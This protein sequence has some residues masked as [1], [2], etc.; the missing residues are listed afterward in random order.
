[1][2]IDRCVYL[3]LFLI[4]QLASSDSG[5]SKNGDDYESHEKVMYMGCFASIL[6]TKAGH[7]MSIDDCAHFCSAE[8]ATVYL[9]AFVNGI[10]CFCLETAEYRMASS[11]CDVTC[12]EDDVIAWDGRYDDDD[13]CGVG[14]FVPVFK[15]RELKDFRHSQLS[16]ISEAS[17]G[18]KQ[19]H[20]EDASAQMLPQI[21]N[22]IIHHCLDGERPQALCSN[23]CKPGW[24]GK[25]CNTRDCT[26]FNGDC[27]STRICQTTI[28]IGGKY[29]ECV[30][31]NPQHYQDKYGNCFPYKNRKNAAF[32]KS[33]LTSSSSFSSSSSS[34]SSSFSSSS[35]PFP[36]HVIDG[37]K[38]GT[39]IFPLLLGE[40]VAVDLLQVSRVHSVALHLQDDCDDQTPP[41]S[42]LIG[43]RASMQNFRG[44]NFKLCGRIKPTDFFMESQQDTPSN[45]K[46]S[47]MESQAE[48]GNGQL[49]VCTGRPSDARFVIVQISDEDD[50]DDGGGNSNGDDGDSGSG[51]DK[52]DGGGGGGKSGGGEGGEV[53]KKFLPNSSNQVLKISEIDV[54]EEDEQVE[55]LQYVGCFGKVS[56]A[57]NTTTDVVSLDNCFRFCFALHSPHLYVAISQQQLQKPQI[58][59]TNTS[60]C[61]CNPRLDLWLNSENCTFRCNPEQLSC[62]GPNVFSVYSVVPSSSAYRICLEHCRVQHSEYFAIKNMEDCFC[63]FSTDQLN[64]Q[65]HIHACNLICYDAN[66]KR[67][68]SRQH[69]SVYKIFSRYNFLEP[70]Q[71]FHFCMNE[72]E[73]VVHSCEPGMCLPG[74]T[75][76]MCDVRNCLEN[77]GSCPHSSFGC[78]TNMVN[79]KPFD[80]CLYHK[81][82]LKPKISCLHGSIT[83]PKTFG[84]DHCANILGA[85]DPGESELCESS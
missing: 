36:G 18:A 28:I 11:L 45:D 1:M 76:E 7:T 58:S 20:S 77:K 39:D 69:F 80:E 84:S 38:A 46:K 27:G 73:V 56:G 53:K 44:T 54:Y 3:L 71:N 62:G 16:G 9:I 4:Q 63:G 81:P 60:T 40:W 35:P 30:C 25:N 55:A 75:G 78:V 42:A 66:S 5:V 51:G 57:K 19:F 47:P 74:W 10:E 41:Y 24:S 68:G 85:C 22:H 23:G 72:L 17:V 61:H 83:G 2:H 70:D 13:D 14:L 48:G 31:Q 67:C 6:H 64:K 12:T 34:S 65:V 37:K 32:R 59:N 26:V 79:K 21:R 43:L 82:I 33:V 50:G 52:D 49:V 15:F 8:P 29:S